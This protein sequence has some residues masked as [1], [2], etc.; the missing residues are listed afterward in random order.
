MLFQT[1]N[2]QVFRITFKY[3]AL[4]VPTKKHKKVIDCRSTTAVLIKID[5]ENREILDEATVRPIV[6]DG[7]IKRIGRRRALEKMLDGRATAHDDTHCERVH[8]T[9]EFRKAVW[10][11]YLSSV[12]KQER[13]EFG[14]KD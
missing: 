4:P 8:Y 3:S 12:G 10:D 5:G 7:F 1:N 2:G 14:L 11:C 9:R 13:A 6:K